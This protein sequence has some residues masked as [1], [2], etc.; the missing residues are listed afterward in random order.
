MDSVFVR[1][2]ILCE[3]VHA[4]GPTAIELLEDEEFL[5]ARTFLEY[6]TC[7]RGWEAGTKQDG[8]ECKQ[9]SLKDAKTRVASTWP[10]HGLLKMLGK[11]WICN[12]LV[13]ALSE[14]A[15]C[16]ASLRS[17]RAHQT[18]WQ[19]VCSHSLRKCGRSSLVLVV[20]DV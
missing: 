4:F 18:H 10:A 11:E 6:V 5:D 14:H 1:S 15:S 3:A 16:M 17:E 2:F 20:V 12:E 9:A 8:Y 13:G 19:K 7:K